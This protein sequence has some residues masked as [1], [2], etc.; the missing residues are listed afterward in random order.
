MVESNQD[1]ES[2]K[3]LCKNSVF[4]EI[5]N[6]VT[7]I[8]SGNV[9]IFSCYFSFPFR[10]CIALLSLSDTDKVLYSRTYLTENFLLQRCVD[11][12]CKQTEKTF[13]FFR[14]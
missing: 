9:F 1:F 13:S 4:Y 7:I 11:A 6:T 3:K 12:T 2:R 5:M 14:Y 10:I 8:L